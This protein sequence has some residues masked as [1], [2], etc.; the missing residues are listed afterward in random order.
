MSKKLVITACIGML[1]TSAFALTSAASAQWMV[2][3]TTLT[4]TETFLELEVVHRIITLK[5][6]GVTIACAGKNI[7]VRSDQLEAPDKISASSAIFNEC[8]SETPTCN[9]TKTIGTVPLQGTATLGTGTAVNMTF[10][11]KTKSIFTTIKYEGAECA[12]LGV[13]PVSGKAKLNVPTGQ[14]EREAQELEADIAEA[15][16]ELKIGSSPAELL[17]VWLQRITTHRVWSFL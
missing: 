2:A 15:S 13:Q 17:G 5:A 9:I 8:S 6:A 7:N 14:T 12:L 4:G 11:P 16:G 3:G 10:T 1:A